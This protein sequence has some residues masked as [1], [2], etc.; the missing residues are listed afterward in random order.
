MM[1]APTGDHTAIREEENDA[2]EEEDGQDNNNPIEDYER[3][4]AELV[5]GPVK[6]S[7]RRFHPMVISIQSED[8]SRYMSDGR[9]STSIDIADSIMSQLDVKNAP[10][11]FQ[12]VGNQG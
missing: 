2:Q 9:P 1:D 10:K 11:D 6:I 8:E 3:S 4:S 7:N 12:K 5:G